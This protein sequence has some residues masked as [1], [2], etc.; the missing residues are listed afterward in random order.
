MD[1][2][3]RGAGVPGG[4]GSASYA[5]ALVKLGRGGPFHGAASAGSTFVTVPAHLTGPERPGADQGGRR[6]V[7]LPA[8]AGVVVRRNLIVIQ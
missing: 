7:S 3:R 1:T 2:G 8:A 5:A 6:D 4:T